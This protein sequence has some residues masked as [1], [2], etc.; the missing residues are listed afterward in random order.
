LV[1]TINSQ[2]AGKFRFKA[3]LGQACSCGMC[4][5]RLLNLAEWLPFSLSPLNT[6][7]AAL[8][9]ST[10]SRSFLDFAG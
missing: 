6:L 3:K 5:G 10:S 2:L 9:L 1:L 7:Q 8:I 4:E